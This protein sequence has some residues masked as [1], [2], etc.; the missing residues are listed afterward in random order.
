MAASWKAE[1]C[2][3]QDMFVNTEGIEICDAAGLKI[4]EVASPVEGT[5]AQH[6]FR[7]TVCR[8]SPT[9]EGVVIF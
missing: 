8:R 9:P 3:G 6:R 1:T 5:P 2:D 7:A 4:G